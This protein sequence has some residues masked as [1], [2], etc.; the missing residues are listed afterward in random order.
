MNPLTPYLIWIKVAAFAVLCI[1]LY[2][3]GHHNGRVGALMEDR[4]IFDSI[5]KQQTE[6]KAEAAAILKKSNDD[7][8][9]TLA[10]RDS[11]KSKLEKEHV[12]NQTFTA[13]LRDK[14]A[15]IGLRFIAK[16]PGC[17][18]GSANAVPQAGEPAGN[19]SAAVIQLPDALAGELRASAAACDTL[20]DDYRLLYDWAHS[21][22]ESP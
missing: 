3:F 8:I 4:A 7:L 17:G 12:D 6:R 19:T 20:K 2:S 15:G 9:A 5:A 13:A 10:E 16:A 11:I 21:A 22:K 18:A 14:Y 1:A